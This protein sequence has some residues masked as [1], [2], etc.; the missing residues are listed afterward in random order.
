MRLH[1]LG[2]P[3]GAR[4]SVVVDGASAD[5]DL[6][7]WAMPSRRL[8]AMN[9]GYKPV[10]TGGDGRRWAATGCDGVPGLAIPRDWPSLQLRRWQG[11]PK[12]STGTVAFRTA[13]GEASERQ[14]NPRRPPVD[15]DA[16]STRYLHL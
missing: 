15:V 13:Y 4:R 2:L 1:N 14:H 9:V 7:S 12:P 11:R 8:T 3:A 16:I 10:E 5:G 6:E